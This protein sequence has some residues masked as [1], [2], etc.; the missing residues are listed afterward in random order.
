[1][2]QAKRI[3]VQT[4]LSEAVAGVSYCQ[5]H[6]MAVDEQSQRLVE[7]V[8]RLLQDDPND[9]ISIEQEDLSAVYELAR[10]NQRIH[11]HWLTKLVQTHIVAS[12]LAAIPIAIAGLVAGELLV[13]MIAMAAPLIAGLLI[14]VYLPCRLLS[15]AFSILLASLR[16]LSRWPEFIDGEDYGM[17]FAIMAMVIVLPMLWPS[18]LLVRQWRTGRPARGA[19]IAVGLLL[20]A[21]VALL[22]ASRFRF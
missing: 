12:W 19:W 2:V 9:R 5:Q 22:F 17:W 18:W 20:V 13:F 8:E 21:E 14:Y 16:P 11:G 7:M 3:A 4:L 10:V 6:R 1:M 15:Y